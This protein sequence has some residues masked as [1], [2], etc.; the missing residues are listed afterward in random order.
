MELRTG[1]RIA[2]A[3]LPAGSYCERRVLPA[4]RL[5]KLPDDI[6]DVTAAA[7]INKG[8]TAHFLAHDTYPIRAGHTV[9]IHAVAGG[10]GLLL[11]QWAK[12]RGASVIGTVG[13]EAKARI[14]AENGCDHPIVYTKEDFVA[15]VRRIT[16]GAGVEVVYDSVGKDTFWKSLQC[17]RPRGTMVLFGIASGH[18]PPLELMKLDVSTAFYFTRPSFH[19]YTHSREDLLAHSRGLFQALSSGVLKATISEQYPLRDAAAAH[20]ALESRRTFGSVVLRP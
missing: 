10:V 18:P 13:N 17:L 6:G 7:T 12:I 1:D 20:R 11:C 4:E 3:T 16:G 8:I 19:V 5:V 2:Y 14:A 9:L 15:V